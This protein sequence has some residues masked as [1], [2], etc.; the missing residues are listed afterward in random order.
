[1]VYFGTA[2]FQRA[3]ETDSNEYFLLRAIGI[4][5]LI[6]G[7]ALALGVSEAVAAFFVGM[8]FSSTDYVH[9]LEHTL[10]PIRDTF[11]AVFFFWVG[12]ITNPALIATASV[13]A[14]LAVAVVLSIPSKFVTGFYSGRIYDL[15]DRQ[16]VR[17]GCGMVTRGEFSL[18][19]ATIALAGGGITLTQATADTINAFAVGYVLVMSIAG[20]MLMQY[21]HVFEERIAG[22]IK[23]PP[24]PI[25][26]PAD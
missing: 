10:E 17:V 23:E 16:S 6:S 11:A 1:L 25:S 13:L 14:I 18:I 15:S 4:T 21:S 8:A 12:L 7:A 2:F 20:S 24:D 9:E 5:V 22:E 19:I 3:L 26:D